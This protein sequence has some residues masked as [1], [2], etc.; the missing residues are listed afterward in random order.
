[1]AQLNLYIAKTNK[2]SCY[3][4]GAQLTAGTEVVRLH[5]TKNLGEDRQPWDRTLLFHCLV[6]YP[7]WLIASYNNKVMNWRRSRNAPKIRTT[8][9]PKQ[10]RPLLHKTLPKEGEIN[11]LKTLQNYHIR[12]G[13]HKNRVDEI[14]TRIEE[15]RRIKPI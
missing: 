14:Q 1:M 7:D 3:I 2:H 9:R 15:L 13:G 6:C 10:G 4:C 8:P 12:K 5:L 11:R